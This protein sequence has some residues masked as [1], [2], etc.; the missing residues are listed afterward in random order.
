MD[1]KRTSEQGITEHEGSQYELITPYSRQLGTG[2][3]PKIFF[4]TKMR[5]MIPVIS[6]ISDTDT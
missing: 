4:G 2:F 3:I 1:L 6:N 5:D